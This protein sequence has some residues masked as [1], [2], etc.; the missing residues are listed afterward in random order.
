MAESNQNKKKG[1]NPVLIVVIILILAV[2]VAVP[3]IIKKQ[4][5][6]VMGGVGT[7][8]DAETVQLGSLSQVVELSGIVQSEESKTY[9]APVSAKIDNCD[10]KEGDLVKAGDLLAGFKINNI[11]FIIRFNSSCHEIIWLYI[12][13]KVKF[14]MDKLYPFNHLDTYGANSF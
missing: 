4:V 2:V 8:V 5:Q 9:F 3:T 10:L 7:P 1:F 11:Y 14:A 13:M 12:T 6:K